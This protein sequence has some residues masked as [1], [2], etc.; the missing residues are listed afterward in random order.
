MD[1]CW[2]CD[3]CN[4]IWTVDIDLRKENKMRAARKT[5]VVKPVWNVWIWDFNHDA[6]K[7]YDVMPII[8]TGLKSYKKKEFPT[9]YEDFCEILD[10]EAAYYFWSKCEWEMIIHGWPAQKNDE[11]VD[12]YDQLKLNWDKFAETVWK[13]VQDNGGKV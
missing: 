5:K 9:T 2:N 10:R 1:I 6:L 7:A 8:L 13:Y 4:S 12:V 3:C 11:K